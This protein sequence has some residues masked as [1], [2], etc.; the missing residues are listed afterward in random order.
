MSYQSNI[1]SRYGVSCNYAEYVIDLQQRWVIPIGS[2]L[3]TVQTDLN[4]IQANVNNYK[5]TVSVIQGNL[6]GFQSN[7]VQNF[8]SQTN[9]A[10]GSFNGVDCRVIG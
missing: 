4:T 2:N 1:Q 3:G 9:Q 6:N 10:S 5:S 7:L 8:N